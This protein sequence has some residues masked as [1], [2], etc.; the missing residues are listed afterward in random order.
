MA[1]VKKEWKGRL[2]TGLNKYI[3]SSPD[4]NGKRQITSSPDSI[5]QEGDAIS[6]TNLNDLE[7]RIEDAF[8]NVTSDGVKD[9]DVSTIGLQLSATLHKGNDNEYSVLE[10][11]VV[12]DIVVPSEHQSVSTPI[13]V[14]SQ[15]TPVYDD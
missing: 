8:S 9:I 14:V 7:N 13:D 12:H 1:Y 3:I 4:E 10:L 2:G 11:G 6:V 15:V 5:T